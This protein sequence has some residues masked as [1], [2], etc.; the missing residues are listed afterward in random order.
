MYYK[1]H[2]INDNIFIYLFLYFPHNRN[3]YLK[4]IF[5]MNF[6]FSLNWVICWNKGYSIFNITYSLKR[7]DLQSLNKSQLNMI[8]NL[9]WDSYTLFVIVWLFHWFLLI[10]FLYVYSKCIFISFENLHCLSHSV[11]SYTVHGPKYYS[12][13]IFQNTFHIKLC[14]LFQKNIMV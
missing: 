8:I 13:T 5:D 1:H 4:I 2:D 14:V 11:K 3:L 6:Y 7:F 10:F 12:L 9:R